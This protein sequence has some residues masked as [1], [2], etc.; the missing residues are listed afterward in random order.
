MVAAV[1]VVQTKGEAHHDELDDDDDDDSDSSSDG[2]CG[3]SAGP[4]VITALGVGNTLAF[5]LGAGRRSSSD[6]DPSAR[7][8]PGPGGA[9]G[10]AGAVGGGVGA[11]GGGVGAVGGGVGAVGGAG[12]ELTELPGASG[13]GWSRLLSNAGSSPSAVISAWN[14][15]T[16]TFISCQKV[17]VGGKDESI[18]IA[19]RT[20]GPYNPPT[21]RR[22]YHQFD[23][24]LVSRVLPHGH[25]RCPGGWV[26]EQNNGGKKKIKLKNSEHRKIGNNNGKGGSDTRV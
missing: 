15:I 13:T 14:R 7:A 4:P 23:V 12:A 10:G 8:V 24:F 3:G 22:A 11:V 21:R 16:S 9:G 18:Q 26:E 25:H 1:V 17:V 19:K 6:E 2:G 5:A 20:R